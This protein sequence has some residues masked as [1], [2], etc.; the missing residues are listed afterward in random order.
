MSEGDEERS[1][2][3]W[4]WIGA[5]GIGIGCCLMF[6]RRVT[7]ERVIEAFGMDPGA[8]RLL[9]EARA[10]EAL[11]FPV[12]DDTGQTVHPWVRAGRAGEWAF[13][14]DRSALDIVDYHGRIARGLS[15]GTDLA[16]FTWTQSIDHF[17]YL[18]DGTEVT[19]FEPMAAWDRFGTEPDRFL[20]EMRQS[21]LS[22][23][24]DEDDE[25]IDLDPRIALLEMLTLSLGIRLP[26]DVALGPLLTVQ[27]RD[28]VS[29]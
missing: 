7:P 21:G 27:R 13:A 22:A 18:A 28:P 10:S 2:S 23:D 6:A 17:R 16:M 26:A 9:P 8:A 5:G 29:Q 25:L 19:E 12:W 14:I 4:D 15:S 20:R 11:S 3:E 24:P 1:A